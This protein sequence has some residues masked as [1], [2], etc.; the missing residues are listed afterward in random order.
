MRTSAGTGPS[1]MVQVEDIDLE[2]AWKTSVAT[3]CT[4]CSDQASTS[5]VLPRST[6]SRKPCPRTGRRGR[7]AATARAAGRE[8]GEEALRRSTPTSSWSSSYLS[9]S[10]RPCS[11]RRPS[12]G[13]AMRARSLSRSGRDAEAGRRVALHRILE[14]ALVLARVRDGRTMTCTQ[15]SLSN[16]RRAPAGTRA[17]G[18]AVD[19][20][21]RDVQRVIGPLA[22]QQATSAPL[23]AAWSSSK[24]SISGCRRLLGHRRSRTA[25]ARRDW[26]RR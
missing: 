20:Q 8:F 25:R 6:S 26:R 5:C 15:G 2:P 9:G 10:T 7:R 12:A 4:T 21:R 18:G 14:L 23:S 22:L 1:P 19:D 3:L 11:A 13:S 16:S 17:K 24:A